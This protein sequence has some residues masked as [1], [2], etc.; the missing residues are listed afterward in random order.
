MSDYDLIAPFYDIEHQH[1]D[2]DLDMYRNFAELTMG[3][4]LELACGSGRLLLPLAKDGHELVGVDT[5]SPM[6]DRAR[7]RAQA[8]GVA[9][10]ITLAQQDICALRLLQKFSFAFIAL[11]SFAHITTRK[12]QQQALAAIRNHLTTGASFIIDIANTD[13]RHLE[14]A[15]GQLLHQGTWTREDGV[16]LTHFIS[17][18]TSSTRHI[19]ELTHFYDQYSQGGPLT[20]TTATMHLYI[21]EH[22]EMEL[23]LAQAGFTIKEVFGDYDLSPYKLESPRMVFV[24]EAR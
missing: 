2:E 3:P 13:L 20:R 9:S 7:E 10:R 5:S 1:F 12:G 21:F 22:G 4:L 24:T 11:G 14:H 16:L 19:L 6:L 17:P 23:L 8:T 18:A 15:A